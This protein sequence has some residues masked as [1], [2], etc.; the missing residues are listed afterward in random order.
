M[1]SVFSKL[2]RLISKGKTV[3]KAEQ[4]Y[5][6]LTQS[7][8]ETEVGFVELYG[9]PIIHKCPGSRIVLGKGTVLVSDN[10]YNPLGVNHP[11]IISTLTP[12]AEIIVGDGV[13]L[14]GTSIASSCS[15]KIGDFCQIGANSNIIDND[16]HSLSPSNRVNNSV[17]ISELPSYPITIENNVWVGLGSTIL[18]GVT[19]GENTVVGACSVVN[20]SMPSNCVCA[21]VPAAI[22]R[23]IK[24]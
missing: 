5:L 11:V 17:Q 13:G 10:S 1:S 23:E 19:I 4:D 15:V 12:N 9:K 3:S 20:K 22:I 7:G 2:R 21:G 16:M 24:E 18:K 6:F 8:V 14:S